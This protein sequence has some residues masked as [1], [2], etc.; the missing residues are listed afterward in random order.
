MGVATI[1][2][3]ATP[4]LTDR[5]EGTFDIK[6]KSE[7]TFE[8][9]G[10]DVPPKTPVREDLNG[11]AASI[12]V[13]CGAPC[14][15][16][17]RNNPFDVIYEAFL[18]GKKN[19]LLTGKVTIILT[20]KDCPGTPLTSTVIIDGALNDIDFGLSDYD[21]DGFKNESDDFPFDPSRH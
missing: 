11:K 5:C 6:V 14:G 9:H 16:E 15:G 18:T 4:E 8:D 21:G 7:W 19:K 1:T 10:L 20:P 17:T 12:E 3:T 2:C 13:E